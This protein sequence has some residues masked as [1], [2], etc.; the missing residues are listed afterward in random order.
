MIRLSLVHLDDLAHQTNKQTN[1]CIRSCLLGFFFLYL[2]YRISIYI[3]I[4]QCFILFF[5]EKET[6]AGHTT[7]RPELCF[8][9]CQYRPTQIH[10][11]HGGCFFA[12]I[13]IFTVF[14]QFF[15]IFTYKVGPAC[16]LS[17]LSAAHG[18]HPGL[19]GSGYFLGKVMKVY[20]WG[21]V[22]GGSI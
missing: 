15:Y 14:G 16:L 6:G 19:L 8:K 4:H 7:R 10:L 1:V 11:H 22:G 17:S 18:V 20:L 5:T 21:R 2:N 12:L 13:S 3:R 9:L